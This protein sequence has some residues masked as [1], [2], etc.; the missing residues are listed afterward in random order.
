[1]LDDS[2]TKIALVVVDTCLMTQVL[3]DEA[4]QLASKQCGIATN[5]MMVS[6]THTHS[7]PAAMACLGTRVDKEYAAWLPAKIAESIVAARASR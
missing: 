1:V 5:H 3:I 7:A 6:A 2:A 4:K